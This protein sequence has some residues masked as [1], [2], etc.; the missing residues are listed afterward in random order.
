MKKN[1]NFLLLYN[2]FLGKVSK[3]TG[4][5]VDI[6]WSLIKRIFYVYHFSLSLTI[7][8]SFMLLLLS[9]S[10]INVLFLLFVCC[11][12]L[13]WKLLHIFFTLRHFSHM[14]NRQIINDKSY[15][16]CCVFSLLLS[17]FFSFFIL[18]VMLFFLSCK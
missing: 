16:L 11:V 1:L 2:L 14:Q 17:L 12:L 4:F 13:C 7:T 15:V 8:L 3:G 18:C 10:F 5:R 9:L 6:F